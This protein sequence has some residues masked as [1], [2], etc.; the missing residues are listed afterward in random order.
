[1]IAITPRLD[2]LYALRQDSSTA[3]PKCI[4]A[5]YRHAREITA[6]HRGCDGPRCDHDFIMRCQRATIYSEISRQPMSEPHASPLTRQRHR[7]A[8]TRGALPQITADERALPD[9]AALLLAARRPFHLSSRR[10]RACASA[11]IRTTLTTFALLRQLAREP[12]RWHLLTRR[13]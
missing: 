9:A 8:A 6:I 2:A 1:M 3:T 5:R 13:T 11:S 10:R 7:D 12:A 4:S